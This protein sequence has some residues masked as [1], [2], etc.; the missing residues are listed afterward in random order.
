MLH[1]PARAAGVIPAAV[2]SPQA[3]R[4]R[5]RAALGA[6]LAGDALRAVVASD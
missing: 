1:A 3:A 4:M 5:L 6:G 2:R